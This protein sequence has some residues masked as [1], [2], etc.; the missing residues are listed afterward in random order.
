[1]IEVIIMAYYECSK[2]SK[3]YSIRCD[4]TYGQT[5]YTR[6]HYMQ[7]YINDNPVAK[8]GTL[9]NDENDLSGSISYELST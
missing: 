4:L 2:P 6:H 8:T 3:K 9:W 5:Y 7:L 1:M